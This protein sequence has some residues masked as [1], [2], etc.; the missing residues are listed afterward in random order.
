MERLKILQTFF[1]CAR[2]DNK[3]PEFISL[4][5]NYRELSDL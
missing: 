1:G 5:T 4:K 2:V 3:M